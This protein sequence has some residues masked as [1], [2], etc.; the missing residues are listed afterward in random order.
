MAIARQQAVIATQPA[1]LRPKDISN[2][3]F[4]LKPDQKTLLTLLMG[5][6][7]IK[8]DDYEFAINIQ[9]ID[10]GYVTATSEPSQNAFTVSTD[11]AKALRIGTTLRKSASVATYVTAINY[12]SGAVTVA[13]STGIADTNVLLVGGT[14]AEELSSRPTAISRTPTQVTNYVQTQRDAWGV[15]THTQSTKFYGGARLQNNREDALYEHGRFIDRELW[16]G[17]KAETTQNS[18]KLFKTGGVFNMVSTN[19]HEFSGGELTWDKLE[20]NMIQDGRFMTSSKGWLF[21][22]RKG[23]SLFNQ[24]VRDSGTPI[25]WQTAADLEYAYV[26]IGNKK[27]TLMV[28]D[29]FEQG[30]DTEM[31]L[32]EPDAI[33]IVTTVNQDTGVRNWMIEKK[34]DGNDATGSDGKLEE[35]YTAFGLRIDERRCARWYNANTVPAA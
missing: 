17:T 9:S 24:L 21:V 6:N 28:V 10:Q 25:E 33:E 30:L 35:V 2:E 14:A 11:D 32:I 5:R 26:R 16:F 22:S 7:K 4:K 27:C 13:D 18:Q 34:F 20:T 12:S 1:G 3:I 8:V 29:H 19:A 15:S 31:V 23:A